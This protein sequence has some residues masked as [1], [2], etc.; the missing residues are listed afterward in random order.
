MK[1]GTSL[2]MVKEIKSSLTSV[3]ATNVKLYREM[4]ETK[5]LHDRLE[6]EL[7]EVKHKFSDTIELINRFKKDSKVWAVTTEKLMKSEARCNN[8][9]QTNKRLK[10]LLLKNHINPNTDA[11]ELMHE[12]QEDRESVKSDKT[13]PKNP[14]K[15]MTVKGR[16]GSTDDLGAIIGLN[17]DKYDYKEGYGFLNNAVFQMSPAYL[18]FYKAKKQAKHE[19]MHNI[20]TFR[21]GVNLPRIVV[22]R[23]VKPSKYF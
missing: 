22:Q 11:R 10:D 15:K 20:D 4:G 13:F 23:G 6:V 14:K 12:E 3:K 19:K 9:V 1:F 5:D 18:G 7:K 2:D 21:P 16:Y 8:L 17:K